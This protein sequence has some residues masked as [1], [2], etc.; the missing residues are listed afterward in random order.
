MRQHSP[1]HTAEFVVVVWVTFA[2]RIPHRLAVEGDRRGHVV[3]VHAGGF[4]VDARVSK[5][6][7][8]ID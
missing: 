2:I 8:I 1:T 7:T 6:S 3:I 5:L 4:R